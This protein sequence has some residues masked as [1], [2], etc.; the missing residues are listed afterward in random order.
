MS[1]LE[2]DPMSGQ[3][4]SGDEVLAAEPPQPSPRP[5]LRWVLAG[6][7]G[8]AVVGAAGA[9]VA[10]ASFLSGGGVQPE[11]LMPSGVVAYAD[12]DLDPA[13][14][15]KANAV[16]FASNFSGVDARFGDANE[17]RSALMD[18]LFDAAGSDPKAV[19]AW[20]GDRYGVAL[21]A[22]D[23]FDLI[24]G[25]PQVVIAVQVTDAD[26][27]QAWLNDELAGDGSVRITQGYALVGSPGVNLDDVMQQADN[28]S[29][30]ESA[31]FQEAMAPLGSGIAQAYFD[32]SALQDALAVLGTAGMAP[33]LGS[34]GPIAAVVRV[35][36]DALE[37]VASTS[38]DSLPGGQK[39]TALFGEL[40]DS[41]A[42]AFAVTG[43]GAALVDRWDTL[44]ASPS[45]GLPPGQVDRELA[46]LER[47][48]GLS[49]PNDLMTLFG[50]DLVVA[51]DGSDL[52]RSPE[53]GAR[54]TTDPAQAERVVGS[55]LPLI[56]E[57]TGGY[58]IEA[59]PTETGW[60]LA[61]TPSYADRLESGD[62]GLLDRPEV[63]AVLPD[64]DGA[65][66]AFYL[67]FAPFAGLLH[68]PQS[69]SVLDT[70]SGIGATT[71]VV[72]DRAVMRLRVT[73]N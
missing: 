3:L 8:L 34:T 24:G 47:K 44:L 6:A 45:L 9:A 1:S 52:A 12:L 48:T 46:R 33:D 61:T 27:A 10:V 15:Q 67:D 5:R 69:R 40:P 58:G 38:A 7:A 29:L 17:I 42:A 13:A 70:L 62:G 65:V 41:T 59:R 39:P 19:E 2:G 37:V 54:V 66:A 11:E 57:A 43:V 50:E 51:L 35:E 30:A 68:D 16:R 36:P 64:I 73:V 14:G 60:V 25:E 49:L 20:L 56:T 18:T 22:S 63:T 55:L 72:D 26:A 21:L 32:P 23:A 53:F 28:E 31:A 71:R 4:Y